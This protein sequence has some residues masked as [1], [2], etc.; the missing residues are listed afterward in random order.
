[1]LLSK[2]LENIKELGINFESS[3][4]YGEQHGFRYKRIYIKDKKAEQIGRVV[5]KVGLKTE[6]I[7]ERHFKYFKPWDKGFTV[8]D[9]IYFKLDYYLNNGKGCDIDSVIKKAKA[10]QEREFIKRKEYCDKN[11]KLRKNK[12]GILVPTRRK[13]VRKNLRGIIQKINYEEK[14]GFVEKLKLRLGDSWIFKMIN[15][16]L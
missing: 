15:Y 8:Q 11:P 3:Q 16:K 14:L 1:M 12:A 2:E 6:E 5:F 7:L 13:C 10:I 4:Y 9:K